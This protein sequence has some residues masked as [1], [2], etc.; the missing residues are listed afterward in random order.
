MVE[1]N[2]K[3]QRTHL[4][5]WHHMPTLLLLIDVGGKWNKFP[6]IIWDMGAFTST[7]C[8]T[9]SCSLP[10]KYVAQRLLLS[11]SIKNHMRDLLMFT[12]QCCVSLFKAFYVLLCKTLESSLHIVVMMVIKMI[13]VWSLL[14]LTHADST[15]SKIAASVNCCIINT[16][17]HVKMCSKESVWPRKGTFAHRTFSK[18]DWA[19]LNAAYVSWSWTLEV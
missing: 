1:R 3:K 5:W 13:L 16:T 10:F 2:K 7:V 14:R 8:T 12:A 18:A 4:R 15:S 9:V 6:R 17:C 19:T 11:F